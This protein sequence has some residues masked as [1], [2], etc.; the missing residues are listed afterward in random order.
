MVGQYGISERVAILSVKEADKQWNNYCSEKIKETARVLNYKIK[1]REE[2][3]DYQQRAIKIKIRF[4]RQILYL[5]PLNEN[6]LDP[7][8]KK[9]DN[10]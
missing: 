2:L 5:I 7:K 3:T 9:R 1:F 10:E 4:G 6:P 8:L